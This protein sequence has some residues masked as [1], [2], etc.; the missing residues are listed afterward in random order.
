MVNHLTMNKQKIVI[1]QQQI[2]NLLS[3]TNDF[4]YSDYIQSHLF[5]VKYELERQLKVCPSSLDKSF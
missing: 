1:A 2:E 4:E 3:L 5:K